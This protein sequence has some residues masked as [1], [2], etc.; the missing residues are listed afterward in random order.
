MK[1]P[2]LILM[3]VMVIAIGA[4]DIRAESASW[5]TY[6][7]A[8]RQYEISYP[9]DWKTKTFPNGDLM[10]IHSI[11]GGKSALVD[12]METEPDRSVAT[13]AA[14]GDFRPIITNG[15]EFSPAMIAG[16]RSVKVREVEQR[17]D[18]QKAIRYFVMRSEH[19]LCILF[20]TSDPELWKEHEPVFDKIRDGLKLR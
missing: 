9:A 4:A 19:P 11:R 15:K 18:T 6:K 14:S 12:V 8:A 13:L 1:K 7:H 5:K 2:G 16:V 20:R 3:F 17:P 10:I